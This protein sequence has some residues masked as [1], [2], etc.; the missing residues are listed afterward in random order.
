MWCHSSGSTA[1]LVAIPDPLNPF[2]RIMTFQTL[3]WQYNIYERLDTTTPPVKH[4]VD[5]LTH[6]WRVKVP[7]ISNTEFVVSATSAYCVE[8]FNERAVSVSEPGGVVTVSVAT[9]VIVYKS[10]AV[11]VPVPGS[12]A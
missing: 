6:A 2:A 9:E 4:D 7:V 1:I 11:V 10:P 3:S 8:P 12:Q 5:G